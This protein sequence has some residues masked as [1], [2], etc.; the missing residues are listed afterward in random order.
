[1]ALLDATQGDEPG[2]MFRLA[3]PERP[4]LEE[5]QRDPG[6]LRIG[7]SHRSPIGTPV[8]EEAVRAVEEAAQLL[9]SLG[10]HVEEAE[11][12]INGEQMTADWLQMWFAHCAATVDMVRALTGCDDDGFEPDTLVMAA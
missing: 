11:P 10:H 5:V 8:H 4:Y 2:A 12:D 1:A 7:F 9:Q 3:P 6:R